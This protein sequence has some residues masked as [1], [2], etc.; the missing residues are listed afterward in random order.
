MTLRRDLLGR[1]ERAA[2]VAVGVS[3][4]CATAALCVAVGED[5]NTP[6]PLAPLLAPDVAANPRQVELGR[7]LF[8]DTR[9]SGDDTVSCATCHDPQQGWADGL[10]MS[11]GY[12]GSLYFRNTPTVLNASMSQFLYWDGRLGGH[13]LATL[14][15]DH[16]AEAHFM[17][18]DGRLVLERMRQVLD[19]E[20]RFIDVFGGEPTYGRILKAVSAFVRTVRSV[21][22]PFDRYL[23]GDETALSESAQRGLALF[24]GKA[25][26]IGCHHGA[27]L[28]DDRFH[29]IGLP[30]TMDI[31]YEPL[32]HI[33]L[34][35]FFRTLGLG[36]AAALRED[37]GLYGVTKQTSDW[38]RF[39]TPTLREV[40]RTPP[41]MH[42]GSLATLE[43]VI[44]FYDRGGGTT[45]H[46]DP[47]L[48]SLNLNDSEKADLIEFLKS[49]S[50]DPVII[51]PPDRVAY[52][53]RRLG[54]N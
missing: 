39:R 43:A 42:D 10:P 33:T 5:R 23:D 26:C 30:P 19:Y 12:P 50:G 24:Q 34:R 37:P 20:R 6:V 3:A 31:F 52:D 46:K 47:L 49:L 1:W 36:D 9:L 41:Y 54:D 2:R 8:F 16:I 51:A 48:Q 15:R 53:L 14:V 17:Q 4:M 27:M 32:R 22:V 35:R 40:A 44:D 18:A 21:N 7:L 11:V 29:N 45:E 28:A 13:D 38:G 25:G